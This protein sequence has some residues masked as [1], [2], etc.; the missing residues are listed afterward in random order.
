MGNC[1]KKP[2]KL[3]N[4]NDSMEWE[5]TENSSNGETSLL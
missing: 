4:L 2:E 3:G 1:Y 5:D